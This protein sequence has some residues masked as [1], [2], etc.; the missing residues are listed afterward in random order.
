MDIS[1][2]Y[3]NSMIIKVVLA[4]LIVFCTTSANANN[5][6]LVSSGLQSEEQSEI[7]NRILHQLDQ[8]IINSDF[9]DRKVNLQKLLTDVKR[10]APEKVVNIHYVWIKVMQVD[11]NILNEDLPYFTNILLGSGIE[12]SDMQQDLQFLELAIDTY[13]EC[14]AISIAEALQI[15]VL[16]FH[17]KVT[18]RSVTLLHEN[19]AN[20]KIYDKAIKDL[21]EFNLI[22][23]AHFD[24]FV[25]LGR[26]ASE[27]RDKMILKATLEKEL[28]LNNF[29]EYISNCGAAN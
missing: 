28:I 29:G 23:E 11:R 18:E 27:L 6:N 22:S 2:R 14:S 13:E 25:E 7:E 21:K 1:G 3:S 16:D 15:N 10:Y 19:L 24:I 8:A 17:D 12:F 9:Q 20:K 26:K 5:E 4:L